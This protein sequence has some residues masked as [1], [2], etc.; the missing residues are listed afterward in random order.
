MVRIFSFKRCQQTSLVGWV[1]I[2]ELVSASTDVIVIGVKLVVLFDRS[3]M[4][5]VPYSV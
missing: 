5:M 4:E 2:E 3:L 1:G